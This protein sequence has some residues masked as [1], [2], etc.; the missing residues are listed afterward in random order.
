[1]N[2][3]PCTKCSFPVYE[4]EKRCSNCGKSLNSHKMVIP[5]LVMF[6]SVL[7]LWIGF[8]LQ[9]SADSTKI[10]KTETIQST[11][12]ATTT[13]TSAPATQP[14]PMPSPTLE[15]E[16]PNPSGDGWVP[17]TKVD[18]LY[19]RSQD[20][21]FFD[22]GSLIA[23]AGQKV[24]LYV[25]YGYWHIAWV[26][27]DNTT[28]YTEITPGQIITVYIPADAVDVYFGTLRPSKP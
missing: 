19:A 17:L 8:S 7:C 2:F 25:R 4:G 26:N 28:N 23:C 1:M 27:P 24:E 15:P 10:S 20:C 9:Q 3:R 13:P 16:F 12:T 21:W 11:T 5:V 14:S 6:L 22:S 18:L